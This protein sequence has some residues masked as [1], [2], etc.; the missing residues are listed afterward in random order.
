VEYKSG[1]ARRRARARGPLTGTPSRKSRVG[2]GRLLLQH[3]ALKLPVDRGADRLASANIAEMR[4][5]FVFALNSR[6]TVDVGSGRVLP[7]LCTC[8]DGRL[9][10]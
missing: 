8:S 2:S 3:W 10:R 9:S 6:T 4:A 5:G 1:R 7:Q